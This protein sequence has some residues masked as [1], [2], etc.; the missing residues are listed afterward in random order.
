MASASAASRSAAWSITASGSAIR[1]AGVDHLPHTYNAKEMAYSKG[2]PVWGAHLA[3]RP[4]APGGIA[5]CQQHRRRQLSS[6]SPARP[7][8]GTAAELSAEAAR[9]LHQARHP[10]DLRRGHHRL[11][12]L[13]A[14]FATEYFRREARSH[15]LR[16]GPDQWLDPDGRRDR[17][18]RNLRHV[19]GFGGGERHRAVPR[20]YLLGASGRLRGGPRRPSTSTRTTGCSIA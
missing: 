17:D 3:G 8:A 19:P 18:Q 15:H 16:Q 5:R 11:R 1:W 12:R 20:L 9:D 13:G 7:A 14:S 10:A 6:R 4:R 2:Q